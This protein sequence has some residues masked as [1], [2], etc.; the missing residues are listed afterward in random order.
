M[1]FWNTSLVFA[2]LVVTI[3]FTMILKM[4]LALPKPLALSHRRWPLPLNCALIGIVTLYVMIFIRSVYFGR[5]GAP[6]AVVLQFLI[7][8]LAYIFGLVLLLRQFP[9]LYPEF[10]VTTG[11]TGLSVRKTVYRKITDVGQQAPLRGEMRLRIETVDGRYLF[12]DLPTRD[13][14]VLFER[15]RCG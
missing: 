10:I 7:A 5:G 8:A 15:L 3:P 11:P 4:M 9:G 6:L 13:V 2:V 1:P 12:L 14:S